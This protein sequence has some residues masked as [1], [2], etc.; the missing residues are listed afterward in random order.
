VVYYYF[1]KHI[2][3]V[4]FHKQLNS[5]QQTINNSIVTRRFCC[6]R[7]KSVT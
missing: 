4:H 6:Q 2:A 7:R 3:F 5:R 1:I